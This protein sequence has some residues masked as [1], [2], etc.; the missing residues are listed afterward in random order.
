MQQQTQQ[1][2]R[3]ILQTEITYK[4]CCLGMLLIILM[5]MLFYN[6]HQTIENLSP[7]QKSFYQFKQSFFQML[8]TVKINLALMTQF[9]NLI[10][11]CFIIVIM[12]AF[13]TQSFQKYDNLQIHIL[14]NKPT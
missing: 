9:S 11:T 6:P 2:V 1:I 12:F 10:K 4:L 13:Q 3:N 5:L 8:F 14:S 7:E